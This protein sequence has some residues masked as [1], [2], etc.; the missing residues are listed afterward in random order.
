MPKKLCFPKYCE[1]FNLGLG[2]VKNV[3]SNLKFHFPLN[4][5]TVG[6]SDSEEK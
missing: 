5:Q 2:P 4:K 6:H 1:V 3:Q